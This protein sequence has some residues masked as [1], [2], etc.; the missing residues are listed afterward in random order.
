MLSP[1]LFRFCVGK[2]DSI[3]TSFF[4]GRNRE[5]KEEEKT[6]I[7]ILMKNDFRNNKDKKTIEIID[8]LGKNRQ[9]YNHTNSQI[10]WQI[11]KLNALIVKIGKNDSL[12]YDTKIFL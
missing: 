1:F 6:I 2:R 11:E 8:T 9:K 3:L 12:Q 5:K 7:I 10:N 4:S